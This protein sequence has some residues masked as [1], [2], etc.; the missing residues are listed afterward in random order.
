[1]VGAPAG[2]GARRQARRPGGF[3]SPGQDMRSQ[4]LSHDSA[5]HH[6]GLRA[7]ISCTPPCITGA[8]FYIYIRYITP[9]PARAAPAKGEEIKTGGP[10]GRLPLSGGDVERSET[11][12]VGIIGAYEV[13]A[14]LFGGRTY[15][16]SAS[17]QT[18]SP[19]APARRA[20]NRSGNKSSPPAQRQRKRSGPSP[21]WT[22]PLGVAAPPESTKRKALE[23]LV[24]KRRFA[25]SLLTAK[26]S[27]AGSP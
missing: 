13:S 3:T 24:S 26:P 15:G 17:R 2:A 21:Q 5:C 1:M 11:E 9:A 27:A 7:N 19:K 6:G 12:R 20:D 22:A 14:D 16:G 23:T 4:A 8:S 18:P 25:R 10:M